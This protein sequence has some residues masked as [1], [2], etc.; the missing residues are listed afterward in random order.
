MSFANSASFAV[1]TLPT[2]N[3]APSSSAVASV[4]ERPDVTGTSSEDAPPERRTT[5]VV[6][7]S[8]SLP[9]DGLVS[10][11]FPSSISESITGFAL[12]KLNT[13][14][15]A[16]IAVLA[17]TCDNP[18]TSGTGTNSASGVE[19]GRI[20]MEITSPTIAA[21]KA[22][23]SHMRTVSP[24]FFFFFCACPVAGMAPVVVG[25]PTPVCAPA[26]VGPV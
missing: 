16:S 11:T 1:S 18:M 23:S 17:C 4:S 3:P 7:T 9:A 14:P 10:A 19:L 22:T 25:S 5:T 12:S 8:A 15:S 20:I 6:P 24:V 21:A 2:T 13:S 26:R